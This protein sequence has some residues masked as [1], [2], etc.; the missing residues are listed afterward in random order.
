MSS[1]RSVLLGLAVLAGQGLGANAADLYGGGLKDGGYAPA[2]ESFRRSWYLRMDGGYTW[3]GKPD[4]TET[5]VC[6]SCSTTYD[7]T[8]T[9]KDD[10]WSLGGG[11]GLNITNRI[12]ADLTYD[13][14]FDSSVEGWLGQGNLMGTRQFDMKSDVF[15]ANLYYDFDFGSRITP[16][17]G[18][19]I[20]FARN[21]TS[22]GTV[23]DEC[24]CGI[25]TIDSGS[26]TNFA[27]AAMAGLA[28][29]LRTGE[30]VVGGG[31]KDAPVVIE[32]GRKLSLDIGYRYLYLGD[33]ETGAVNRAG[34][35]YSDDPTVHNMDAHQI[36]IGLRYN[37]Q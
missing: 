31:M 11:V 10:N 3:N 29:T 18:G 6:G 24:G 16:Y 28:I 1:M 35:T 26:S 4:I 32:T 30:T 27:A 15:L 14:L 12:R 2:V 36:R 17:I 13:H 25:G 7:L 5:Q 34:V 21:K 22:S 33:A 8:D 9:S 19:G 37:L 20:G 23:T